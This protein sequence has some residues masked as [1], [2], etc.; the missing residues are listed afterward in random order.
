M[1]Q[2]CLRMFKNYSIKWFVW[3]RYFSFTRLFVTVPGMNHNVF[4]HILQGVDNPLLGIVGFVLMR[5]RD[6]RID[7]GVF[8]R[9]WS[10]MPDKYA[11]IRRSC[12]NAC[13]P[14][15][16]HINLQDVPVNCVREYQPDIDIIFFGKQA[17]IVGCVRYALLNLAVN[18]WSA[19]SDHLAVYKLLLLRIDSTCHN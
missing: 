7:H 4:T 17:T 1:Q 18:P 13:A 11:T 9:Y 12:T 5:M 10:L 8:V 19:S 6:S 14:D 2:D 15:V 3:Q 16:S